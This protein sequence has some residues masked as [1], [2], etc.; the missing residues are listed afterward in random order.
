M[1]R[2]RLFLV[3][4]PVDSLN[5][6]ARAAVD[7]A[8]Q[9]LV[10]SG[11][12]RRIDRALYDVSDMNRLTGKPTTPH[13]RAVIEAVGRRALQ[14]PGQRVSRHYYDVYRM[15]E[16]DARPR[17]SADGALAL[18]CVRHA[19]M[20]FDRPDLDL[21]SA[22][23]GTLALRP[24]PAMVAVLRRDYVRMAGMITE[25][26]PPFDEVLGRIAVFEGEINN[27]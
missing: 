22:V 17:A 19:R 20:F 21:A 2:Q 5:L 11:E 27:A 26:P 25:Q 14:H 23:P 12:I 16:S 4:T 1:S 13:Y 15:L 24:T 18:D 9:R 8:L 6:G 7:K 10:N 3:W